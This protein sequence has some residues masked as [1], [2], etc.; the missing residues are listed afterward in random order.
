MSDKTRSARSLDSTVN[1]LMT[2]AIDF[3]VH[4]GPDPFHERRPDAYNLALSARA[5]GMRGIVCKCH[6]YGTAPLVEVVNG[7][8]P[9]FSLIGSLVLNESV[10][11][12]NPEVVE[13]AAKAG[14]RV[15]WMPT[16]SSTSDFK[17][18]QAGATSYP[19]TVGRYAAT[20][21]IPLIDHS[22]KL[23]PQ[24][25]PILEIIKS[26]DIVLATG[27][28]SVPEIYALTAEA[29]RM[30]I[31]VTITHP[32]STRVGSP[33]N[34]EQQ[35]EMVKLGAYIEHTFMPCMPISERISPAVLVEHVKGVG[36]EHCLLT[37]DFGQVLLP[38]PPEGFRM[39]VAMLLRYGLTE[40]EL[41][42][43]VKL[44]PARLL[45]LD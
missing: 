42:K 12:L 36:A 23:V 14:A 1:E 39:M 3:H 7:V 18:K 6:H 19:I 2:G 28:I 13:V 25:M 11:G 16:Y 41:E 4:T 15:I 24:V 8:V 37:T 5:L 34:L 21:P 44:N 38:S 27:H 33:L 22:G 45:G 9:G 26:Q 20:E 40:A 29:R 31:K 32:L 10:G 35:R 43:A 30:D 17:R